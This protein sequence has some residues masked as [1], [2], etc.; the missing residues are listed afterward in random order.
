MVVGDLMS[1]ITLRL[2][3]LQSHCQG[4]T[5]LRHSRQED[6]LADDISLHRLNSLLTDK[7]CSGKKGLNVCP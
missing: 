7:P 6:L 3:T 1:F 5:I 2:S 4:I